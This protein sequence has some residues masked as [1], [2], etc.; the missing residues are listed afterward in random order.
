MRPRCTAAATTAPQPPLLAGDA[1][2]Q[3]T[4]TMTAGLANVTELTVGQVMIVGDAF[5]H[6]PGALTV[7]QLASALQTKVASRSRGVRSMPR[8]VGLG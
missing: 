7:S 5:K 8:G 3:V 4:I 1:N 6:D 2:P